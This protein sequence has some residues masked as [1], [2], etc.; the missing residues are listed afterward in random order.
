MK[1][2]TSSRE[3]KVHL[4]IRNHEHICINDHLKQFCANDLDNRSQFWIT[5]TEW[6][7][8]GKIKFEKPFYYENSL[9]RS[10]T[11]LMPFFPSRE[12]IIS[13]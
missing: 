6:H 7:W 11:H 3:T 9:W 5:F 1:Y 10:F 2:W 4:S 8:T 13:K 12:E